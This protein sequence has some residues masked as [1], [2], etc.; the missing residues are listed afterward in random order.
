MTSF[1]PT[2]WHHSVDAVN[3][4]SRTAFMIIFITTITTKRPQTINV[5]EWI[6]SYPVCLLLLLFVS[7]FVVCLDPGV[8]LSLL[9]TWSW[10]ETGLR[11]FTEPQQRGQ[12]TQ[13]FT[14]QRSQCLKHRN[15]YILRE[16]AMQW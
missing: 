14:G 13:R 4:T 12:L 3:A 9:A 2:T 1:L 15:D 11:G 7:L 8:R 16:E 10:K 5:A 6:L